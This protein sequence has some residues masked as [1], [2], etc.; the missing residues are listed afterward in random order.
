VPN[1]RVEIFSWREGCQRAMS[2]SPSTPVD[3]TH[4]AG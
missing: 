1:F 2:G 3:E 4:D